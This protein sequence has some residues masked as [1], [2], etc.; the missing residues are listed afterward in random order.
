M[1]HSQDLC[2]A[3]WCNF[4]ACSL[5]WGGMWLVILSLCNIIPNVIQWEVYF[6]RGQWTSQLMLCMPAMATTGPRECAHSTKMTAL[7]A[8]RKCPLT[9]SCQDYDRVDYYAEVRGG[10]G[11]VKWSLE[12]HWPSTLFPQACGQGTIEGTHTHTY[13]HTCTHKQ[14]PHA[15]I[16]THNLILK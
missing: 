9:S 12:E 10:G 1:W 3:L 5:R 15:H 13:M 7:L 6:P 8:I 11:R 4:G 16:H 2:A 14:L